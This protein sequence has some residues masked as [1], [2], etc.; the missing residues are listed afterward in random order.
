MIESIL[1][2]T[3]IE[4][5]F[6]FAKK[7]YDTQNTINSN[8][9]NSSQILFA[10]LLVCFCCLT[11]YIS[12]NAIKKYAGFL[13]IL[14]SG[15]LNSLS[16]ILLANYAELPIMDESTNFI[17]CILYIIQIICLLVGI[18]RGIALS[19]ASS[20]IRLLG[21]ILA[22]SLFGYLI[23]INWLFSFLYLAYI[24]ISMIIVAIASDKETSNIKI[25]DGILLNFDNVVNSEDFLMTPLRVIKD[26]KLRQELSYIAVSYS[27]A[28][29]RVRNQRINDYFFN[30]YDAVTFIR[31]LQNANIESLSVD[32]SSAIDFGGAYE[33]DKTLFKNLTAEQNILLYTYKEIRAGEIWRDN[34]YN[35][36]NWAKKF[37]ENIIRSNKI[38]N[39][40]Y[41]VSNNMTR[42]ISNPDFYR[43][44]DKKSCLLN[45]MF[46]VF[47]SEETN[48]AAKLV[49]DA[50]R[51]YKILISKSAD[52]VIRSLLFTANSAWN[53][54]ERV[55]SKLNNWKIYDSCSYTLLRQYNLVSMQS[56]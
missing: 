40:I 8:I 20:I 30:L 46:L 18:I 24:I 33:S 7:F 41:N 38:L 43:S 28:E 44:L 51:C 10:V 29:V 14:V 49:Y 55:K 4:T 16:I 17:I 12:R 56:N 42:N 48:S 37:F 23:S 11:F 1:E 22:Q 6:T 45:L 35:C 36:K 32:I 39:H 9:F 15:V 19:G 13:W 5:L 26:L 31:F 53:N 25:N 21:M 3:F 50:D 54:P 27:I 52:H 34:D 47:I 2:S